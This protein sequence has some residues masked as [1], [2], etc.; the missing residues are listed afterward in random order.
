MNDTF[1][2]KEETVASVSNVIILFDSIEMLC[3]HYFNSKLIRKK[4]TRSYNRKYQT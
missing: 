4:T 3:L 2:D 1:D